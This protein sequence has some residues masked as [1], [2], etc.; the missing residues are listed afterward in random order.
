MTPKDSIMGEK[1]RDISFDLQEVFPECA[2]RC[3]HFYFRPWKEYPGVL[4]KISF[5]DGADWK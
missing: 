1:R 5:I 3:E 4:H 2:R